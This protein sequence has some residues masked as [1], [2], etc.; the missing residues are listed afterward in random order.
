MFCFSRF[1]PTPFLGRLP[2]LELHPVQ[3]QHL[4]N[5]TGSVFLSISADRFASTVTSR[6]PSTRLQSRHLLR[7]NSSAR[8]HDMMRRENQ[9][10]LLLG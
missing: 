10:P 5:Y 3:N 8:M 2:V 4:P 1:I 7:K 9:P 6:D